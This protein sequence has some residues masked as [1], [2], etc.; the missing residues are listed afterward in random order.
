MEASV[1]IDV[2]F[3]CEWIMNLFLLWAAGHISGFSAKKR[4]LLLGAF[5]AAFC[6]C[7]QLVFFFS[8][9][10]K[11][12]Q[13]LGL[14]LLGLLAA[15]YPKNFKNL[16]RLL[17]SALCAS[18]L[19]GGGLNVLFATTQ[20]QTAFGEGLI[21]RQK[22][23]PWQYLLWG[24]A[25]G[26]ICLKGAARWLEANIRRRRDFCTVYIRRSGK[27]IEGRTLIDTGN[28]LKREGRGVIIMEVGTL[29]PLFSA[30]EG[31]RMLS[32][33]REGLLPAD[34]TSLGNPEGKLWGFIADECKISFGEK[35]IVHDKLYIGITFRLFTGAY[36]GLLPPCLI[37]EEK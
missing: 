26:Y 25:M 7:V 2:V 20:M 13:S 19:L 17:L 28:G 8:Y 37:E 14:L 31:E 9:R 30:E 15:Y 29:L 16:L 23:F 3:F 22:F 6:H 33:E 24:I 27:W 18:F 32:R 1:Y 35:M 4:R 36:E 34:Y 12:L 5:L 21:L 10:A 11:L